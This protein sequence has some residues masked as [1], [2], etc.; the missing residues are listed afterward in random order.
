M[1][2]FPSAQ[3]TTGISPSGHSTGMDLRDY[4]AAKA[5]QELIIILASDQTVDHPDDRRDRVSMLAYKQ[6]DS[7]LQERAR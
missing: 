3:Y 4:F 5:M 2:A 7:M 1:N 6:A